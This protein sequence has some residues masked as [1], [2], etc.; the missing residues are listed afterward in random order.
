MKD[1]GN[2]ALQ[3]NYLFLV[4]KLRGTEYYKL[5]DS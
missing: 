3:K 1:Q 2:M 5:P 4:V